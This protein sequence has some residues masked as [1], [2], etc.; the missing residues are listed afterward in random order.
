MTIPRRRPSTS[1]RIAALTSLLTL[2]SAGAGAS[3][4]TVVTSGSDDVTLGLHLEKPVFPTDHGLRPWSSTLQTDLRFR[5][6]SNVFVRAILPLAFAGADGADGT[7]MYLGNVGATF[8]FGS[9]GEPGSFLGFTLP[10]ASN[11]AGPDLAVLVAVLPNRDEPELWAD[12][13]LSVRGGILPAWR[14]SEGTAVGLRLG[15]A[16]LAPNDFGNVW[17]YARGGPWVSASAGI[18]EVRADL[19]TSYFINGDDGFER[20][21]AAYL[22]ARAGLTALPGRPGVIVHLP[23][24]SE[25]RDALDLSIGVF[26]QLGL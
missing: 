24:D 13:V 25:A 22:D 26:A 7:S 14:P 8:V 19:A 16:L 12:D 3:A 1:L 23:L 20:Q 17:L 2:A 9:S 18:A 21:F 11:V 6:S 5:W 15:G 10:T 4:Q